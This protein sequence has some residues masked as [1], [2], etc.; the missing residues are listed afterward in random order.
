MVAPVRAVPPPTACPLSRWSFPGAALN[1]RAPVRSAHPRESELLPAGVQEAAQAWFEHVL[2]SRPWCFTGSAA[3]PRLRSAERRPARHRSRRGA[4]RPVPT[5]HTP[6]RRRAAPGA[7]LDPHATDERH[8][9]I[10][11]TLSAMAKAELKKT[12]RSGTQRARGS[13]YVSVRDK[14]G[15]LF[16]GLSDAG[17]RIG[18]WP[19][20][21]LSKGASGVPA[22]LGGRSGRSDH[23]A[24]TDRPG[25]SCV[26]FQPCSARP[27]PG[28]GWAADPSRT[29]PGYQR[30][31]HRFGSALRR[32][33][34][35]S[36]HLVE[37]KDDPRRRTHW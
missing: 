20:M 25:M 6:G 9:E 30:R 37:P 31:H 19:S 24:S 12:K 10:A 29:R 26:V 8:W 18:G 16:T 27:G 5:S 28:S 11:D 23:V 14:A 21:R 36:G 1:G 4:R 13:M 34:Y 32:P 33:A 15:T 2:P 3:T 7:A 17:G 35:A 22:C